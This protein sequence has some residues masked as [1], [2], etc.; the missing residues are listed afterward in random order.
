MTKAVFFDLFFTL[1][2]PCYLDENEFDVIGISPDEWEFYAEND[3]LYKERAAGTVKTGKEIIDR[4]VQ[5][6]PY[7]LNDNQKQLILSRRED[8]MRKALLTV[9]GVI[10]KNINLL[11]NNGIKLGLISNADVIDIKYWR[12]SPLAEFFDTVIFS[13]DAGILKPE[14]EIYLL[15]MEALK[16]LPEESIFVGDGGSN[17]LYGAKMAGMKTIFTEY[18]ESKSE[19]SKEQIILSAD[20]HVRGF[21]E[22]LQYVEISK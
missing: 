12:E 22:I 14:V 5:I 1:A 15:A 2:D 18:L 10:L 20:Y 4:I 16:V 21:D 13:C 11:H 19:S 3:A 9:D 6:M 7:K 8:R 17:E